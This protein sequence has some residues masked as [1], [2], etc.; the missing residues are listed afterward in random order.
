MSTKCSLFQTSVQSIYF[1]HVVNSS[2]KK[3]RYDILNEPFEFYSRRQGVRKIGASLQIVITGL[4]NYPGAA[5]RLK[6]KKAVSKT[7]LFL[8][9]TFSRFKAT[10]SF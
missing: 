4:R 7:P 3:H 8:K 5:A 9:L 10:P 2:G 1:L 6:A